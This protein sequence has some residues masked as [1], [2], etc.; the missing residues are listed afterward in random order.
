VPPFAARHADAPHFSF[1]TCAGSWILV[2]VPGSLGLPGKAELLAAM[3]APHEAALDPARALIVVI[4]TD[5]ADEAA[6]RLADGPARRVLWDDTGAARRALRATRPDGSPRE[7]WV[8]LDPS[9][10]VFGLWPFEAGAE[11]LGVLAAL[12]PPEAHAGVPMQA[13]VLIVP[14]VFEPAFCRRLMAHHRN[15]LAE[16]GP[17]A[18]VE[19]EEPG[20]AYPRRVRRRA[21]LVATTEL[22]VQI[23]GRLAMR[24]VPEL[25]R[26]FRFDATR[27]E[28]YLVACYDGAERGHFGP[29][30]DDDA[31]GTAHRRFAATINLN[32]DEYDGG[33]LCFPEY[34]PRTYRA[35]AGGALVYACSLLH[36]VRPVTRGRRFACLP[37]LF[38]EEAARQRDAR[39]GAPAT[40]APPR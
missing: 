21:V 9:L 26:A 32:G 13:P 12:P 27:M 14:R 16:A 31:P 3:L 35:P 7:G 37:F 36:E 25:R 24:L 30:R 18:L 8:L 19:E 4:G 22:Q 10:R 28:R 40:A 5:P 38:D 2:L 39:Q 33:E 17:A 1:D 15:R 34:G 23:R 6:G 20:A 29:H 11:A